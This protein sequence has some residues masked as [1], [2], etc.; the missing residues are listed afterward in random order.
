MNGE[1]TEKIP[2]EI[3]LHAAALSV[4]CH[5]KCITIGNRMGPS[6]IKD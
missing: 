3:F 5:L 4:M 6:K 2:F 1:L